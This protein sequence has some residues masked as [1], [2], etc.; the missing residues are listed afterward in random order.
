M[1]FIQPVVLEGDNLHGLVQYVLDHYEQKPTLLYCGS[2]ATF[3]Q[4]LMASVAPYPAEAN[5]LSDGSPHQG[6]AGRPGA[7]TVRQAAW[8]VPTLRLLSNS[9]AVKLAFCPDNSHLRAYLTTY[10]HHTMNQQITGD[11]TSNDGTRMLVIVNLIHLHRPTS[12][13]SVQGFN[14]TFASAVEAASHLH[15]KL[16]IV[17]CAGTTSPTIGAEAVTNTD[18]AS[19]EYSPPRSVW[20]EEVSFLNFST[21]TFGAGERGWVG[22]TAKLRDVAARW[23]TFEMM[24]ST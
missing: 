8:D 14:R 3:I 12:A 4:A 20:D 1:A 13:F 5:G 2:K 10:S 7:T 23:C 22:R 9:R 18:E 24:G 17:E 21:K 15:S 16:V 6:D 11:A 19:D